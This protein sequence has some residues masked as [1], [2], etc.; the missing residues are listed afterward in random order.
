M[1]EMYPFDPTMTKASNRIVREQHVITSTNFR[2]YHYVIPNFAPFFT[3]SVALRLRLPDGQMRPLVEGR[4]FYFSHQFL[5]ASAT[6]NHLVNGSISFLDTDTEGVLEIDYHTIGGKWTLTPAQIIEILA[7]NLRNPRITSWEFVANVPERFPV[8]DH[9][10]DIVDFKTMSDVQQSIDAVR[11]AILSK[12]GG[13]LAGHISN[14]S[15]PHNVTK[16]QVGLGSVQ[17][18]SIATTL[19]AEAGTSNAKYMTPLRTAEAIAAQAGTLLNS[20]TNRVDNPHQVTKAQ[21]GLGSVLNYGIATQAEAEAGTSN[22]KYMTPLTVA[23][24]IKVQ[25][26]DPLTFHGQRTDNPHQVTKSQIGLFNV[27]NYL[28]ATAQ[29]ARDGDRNDRYMTPLRTTQLVQQYVFNTLSG[30]TSDFTNPHNTT[31]AQ[32]GL[33]NVENYGVASQADAAAGTRNDAYMTPLRTADAIASLAI[34]PL[35]AHLNDLNNP[36]QTTKAHVGLGSVQNYPVAS[37]AEAQVGTRTDRYMTPA[38][39]LDAITAL[40]LA[41]LNAHIAD[42]GNPHQTT[43]AQVG[44]GNVENYPIATLA[45]AQAGTRTDRYMTPALVKATVAAVSGDLGTHAT[46]Y[47]NP[48]QTTKAQVGLGNVENY[49]IASV[50]EMYDGTATNKYVTPQG[51]AQLTNPINLALSNHI[52]N[53]NNPHGVTASQVGAYSRNEIDTKIAGFLGRNEVA[54]DSAL[55]NGMTVGQL[56]S[57]VFGST[58]AETFHTALIDEVTAGFIEKQVLLNATAGMW[59]QMHSLATGASGGGVEGSDAFSILKVGG[60][61]TSGGITSLYGVRTMF[62][63]TS[64][65]AL[66]LTTLDGSA[67]DPNV[68]FGFT[69]SGSIVKTF[70]F[71][72]ANSGTVRISEY[73]NEAALQLAE[74]GTSAPAGLT[75]VSAVNGISSLDQRVTNLEQIINGISIV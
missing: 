55:F 27:E 11:D 51:V 38:R 34:V 12:S 23:Q 74:F 63:P 44:L 10:H 56:Y 28:I 39:T 21:V 69:R 20:H 9:P 6:T 60:A 62:R 29:E 35:N 58:E 75:Q 2:N 3:E 73:G 30:H 54:A 46:N 13:G 1:A 33:G 26:G 68:K 15:N 61:K 31:K 53:T 71:I 57:G 5:D 59:Y 70:V 32:V 43:K 37:Q 16:A 14:F 50:S 24:A 17:N 67:A 64:G 45:E 19:E 7:N 42:V 66:V 4:D 48:H 36:H 72:P 52:G 8:V 18:Y 65:N 41:P 47:S 25:V 40:A 49:G 22:A